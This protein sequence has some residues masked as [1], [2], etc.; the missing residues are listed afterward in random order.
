MYAVVQPSKCQL[1]IVA[2]PVHNPEQTFD[3][4]RAAQA[5]Q[6]AAA[7]AKD[8]R[9]M[10]ANIAPSPLDRDGI[11]ISELADDPDMAQIIPIYVG[12]FP[13]KISLMNAYLAGNQ[14]V[15]LARLAHQLKGTGG[16]YGF[17]SISDAACRV[18]QQIQSKS[19]IQQIRNAVSEL[20]DLRQQ[21]IAG[22]VD[23]VA[24]ESN[25]LG[26]RFDS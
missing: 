14:L 20:T 11:L 23:L 18:G 21:A 26:T 1:E 17:P 6:S 8:S 13:S 12:R 7:A 5:S 16:G 2:G 4:S 22:C 10:N 19:D 9:A 15:E 24:E 25:A 3:D